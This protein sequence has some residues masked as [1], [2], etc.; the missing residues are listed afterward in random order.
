GAG[1]FVEAQESVHLMAGADRTQAN[2]LDADAETRLWNRTA[3]PIETDPQ[4][5]GQVVQ[6][7]DVGIASGAQVRAVRDVHLTATEGTHRAR[8]FGE[9]T[10]LYREVLSA[11]GEFFGADTSSLKIT[12]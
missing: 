6:H 10:D 1:A 3:V 9:G 12:G 5:H 7:N 4:A 2:R 11:I 8:G